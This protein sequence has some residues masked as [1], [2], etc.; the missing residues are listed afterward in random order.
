[1]IIGVLARNLLYL[2]K[3]FRMDSVL[4]FFLICMAEIPISDAQGSDKV[5]SEND[6]F[7][8]RLKWFP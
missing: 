4:P 6:R 2:D 8:K 7:Y 1:M 3:K 5:I